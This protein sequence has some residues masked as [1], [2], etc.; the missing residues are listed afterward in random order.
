MAGMLC[1]CDAAF[2]G[3]D[4]ASERLC[5]QLDPTSNLCCKSSRTSGAFLWKQV[6]HDFPLHN[7][8]P[9]AGPNPC[10]HP[11]GK[12]HSSSRSETNQLLL[13]LVQGSRTTAGVGVR[14]P[15][16]QNTPALPQLATSCSAAAA[17]TCLVALCCSWLIGRVCWG[18]S[19]H[20]LP[21]LSRLPAA[22]PW[23][24]HV[25]IHHVGI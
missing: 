15:A 8:E 1:D 2:C 18:C 17:F 24:V 13:P 10:P 23:L 4:A 3:G 22:C 25:G 16:P 6:G 7:R 12:Q 19:G 9:R 11:Q 20:R 14:T 21:L 5:K